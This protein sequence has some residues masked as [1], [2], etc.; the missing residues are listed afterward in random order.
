MQNAR[1]R[2]GAL[3]RQHPLVSHVQSVVVPNDPDGGTHASSSPDCRHSSEPFPLVLV[4]QYRECGIIYNT[5][6]L[7]APLAKGSEYYFISAQYPAYVARSA[8]PRKEGCS[9]C[10]EVASCFVCAHAYT[11]YLTMRIHIR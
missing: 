4:A 6:G 11:L 10:A 3:R 7:A 9:E 5:N 2:A 8:V 1:V